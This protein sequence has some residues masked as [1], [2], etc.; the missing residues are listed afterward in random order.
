MPIDSDISDNIVEFLETYL[1]EEGMS[2]T[3]REISEGCFIAYGT[4]V[5]YLDVLEAQGVIK[6]EPNKPRST[7][8][9][10]RNSKVDHT[11]DHTHHMKKNK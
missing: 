6:R 1:E 3:L 11:I 7:R 5:R 10:S 9:V 4:V 2:P 8:L